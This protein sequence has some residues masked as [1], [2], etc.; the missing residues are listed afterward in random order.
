MKKSINKF[1]AKR[2]TTA[3]AIKGGH[4]NLPMKVIQD[5]DSGSRW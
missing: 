3:I 2:V 4:T 1:L 5:R